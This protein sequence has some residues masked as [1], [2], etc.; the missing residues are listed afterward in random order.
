MR[1]A[2]AEENAPFEK[3][4]VAAS[5]WITVT[6]APLTRA[7]SFAAIAWSYSRLVTRVAR[8]PNSSVAA[9]GPAPSSSTCSP[10]SEPCRIH[11]RSC[12]R[13]TY[14]QNGDPQN[15]VSNRFID[16]SED[17]EGSQLYREPA[18]LVK[19]CMDSAERRIELIGII[20]RWIFEL[21]KEFIDGR[22]DFSGVR[23]L[24]VAAIRDVQRIHRHGG[25]FRRALVRQRDIL[26]V[27]GNPLQHLQRN[28]L[29]V[30]H[31]R[32]PFRSPLRE[33]RCSR[34]RRRDSIA[35]RIQLT[36][37]IRNGKQST[38]QLLRV[39]RIDL[40]RQQSEHRITRAVPCRIA[41]TPPDVAMFLP[42]T[43]FRRPQ[44]MVTSYT[45]KLRILRPL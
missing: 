20:S 26:C 38:V 28:G 10:S 24:S 12:R 15:H 11:G 19:Q 5:P 7:P 17:F 33:R 8:C 36:H 25:L 23:G 21:L 9:P 2:I 30:L 31:R 22:T 14:R 16:G 43:V 39:R 13:V 45:R 4:N 29:I 37:L 34:S 41:R 18:S 40:L 32:Q 1:I 3:G 44:R 27:I 42:P 6:L 35:I